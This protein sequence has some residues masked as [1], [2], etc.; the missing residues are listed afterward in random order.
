MQRFEHN[1]SLMPY[2]F[3]SEISSLSARPA[4]FDCP[5]TRVESVTVLSP[6][7]QSIHLSRK[8]SPLLLRGGRLTCRAFVPLPLGGNRLGF[9]YEPDMGYTVDGSDTD[10][11][12][13]LDTSDC[14]LECFL[15]GLLLLLIVAVGRVGPIELGAHGPEVNSAD[16]RPVG[17][18]LQHLPLVNKAN[19]QRLA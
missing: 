10:E 9:V 14:P 3:F 8:L 16:G 7:T 12:P 18:R 15:T 2:A 17:E 11:G 19:S 1:R 4:G 13:L 6:E 5:P